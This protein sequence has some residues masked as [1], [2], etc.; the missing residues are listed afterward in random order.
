MV[1][2]DRYTQSRQA[3]SITGALSLGFIRSKRRSVCRNLYNGLFY[4]RLW[5]SIYLL[6]FRSWFFLRISIQLQ[7]FQGVRAIT[8]E[9]I[10]SLTSV[11]VRLDRKRT[12]CNL[13]ILL[14][15]LNSINR[16]FRRF[17]DVKHIISAIIL[18]H[19]YL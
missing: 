9:N 13:L 1:L 6:K 10:T 3:R 11:F 15:P 5:Y 7:Y 8:K 14:I 17:D 18:M 2:W 4:K 19:M 12:P 16:N